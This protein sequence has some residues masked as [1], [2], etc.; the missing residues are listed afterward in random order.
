[1]NF[2]DI[3]SPPEPL[4]PAYI[5]ASL[6]VTKEPPGVP[7]HHREIPDAIA[8]ELR[9]ECAAD[10]MLVL[11]HAPGAEPAELASDHPAADEDLAESCDHA[12]TGLAQLTSR[13]FRAKRLRLW[14]HDGSFTAAMPLGDGFLTLTGTLRDMSDHAVKSC[15]KTLETMQ[16]LIAAY[17]GQWLADRQI[18]SLA[19]SLDLAVERSGIATIILDCNARILYANSSAEAIFQ[20]R[21]GLRRCGERMVCA[22]MA[23]T[24]RLQ[25][26]IDHTCDAA[27]YHSE[28]SPMLALPRLHRRALT[29]VLSAL[30]PGDC[31]SPDQA[32]L[33]AY[34]FDPEQDVTDFVEPVCTLYGLSHR[35]TQLTC[36]LVEGDCINTAAKRLGVRAQ[37]ARSYLKQIFAKTE[38]NRQTDLLQLLLK[39]AISIRNSG[40]IRAYI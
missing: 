23:D 9:R 19:R 14:W 2:D 6:P 13:P 29:A 37:T 28:A 32:A 36:A 35:E 15:I 30:P 4:R 12:L 26:A 1:M 7:R 22:S 24:L 17:F 8:G 21:D 5:H 11:W 27:K 38:T 31:P 16:P 20:Q 40:G 34:V 3:I 18:L 25:A 39:S 10:S 33:I